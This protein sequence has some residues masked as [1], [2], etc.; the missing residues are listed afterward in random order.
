MQ[1]HF[2]YGTETGTAEFLCEDM[3]EAAGSDW[4]TEVSSI[5]TMSPADLS[6]DDFY[7]LV[8]STYGTG[9]LP[10]LALEF[11]EALENDKPNLSHVNFA[12]FG[13][14]DETFGETYNKG[15]E[16]LMTAMLACKAT[17]IGERGLFNAAAAD[18]PEDIGVPWL[19]GI[20]EGMQEK[21]AA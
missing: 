14:G 16:R 18:M 9:D 2:L 7:I 8:T 21:A 5:D 20:L 17:M 12:I 11:F 4:T 13:L 1:L 15:S 10:T 3:V 6:A 19:E